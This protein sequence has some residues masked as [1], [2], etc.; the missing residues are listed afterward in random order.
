MLDRFKEGPLVHLP[1]EA[2]I[3]PALIEKLKLVKAKGV[4]FQLPA[5]KTYLVDTPEVQNYVKN[6]VNNFRN[7]TINVVFDLTPNFVTT[8]DELYRSALNETKYRGAFVWVEGAAEPTKWRSLDG[9]NA[10]KEVKAQNWVLSQFGVNN[11]DLQ[12]NNPIAKDKFKNVLQTL[13]SLGVKGFRLANAKH[14]IIDSKDLKDE[15][16][17]DTIG[18]VHD[19][20]NFWNHQQTTFQPGLGQ[21]LEEFANTVRNYTNNEGFLA[22]SN[23]VERPEEF[24][25]DD[26]HFGFDLPIHTNLPHTLT[27]SGPGV[28]KQLYT[29]LSLAVNNLGV[30][31]WGQWVYNGTVDKLSTGLSEY[32][33]FLFL[34]PGVPVGTVEHFVGNNG[35]D[36]QNLHLLEDIRSGASYQHGTF[37][38]Y[39]D[40]NET[41]VAY[42]RFVNSINL[43]L[44]HQSYLSLLT[45]LTNLIENRIITLTTTKY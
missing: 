42:T 32:N 20:Y 40:A 25:N 43:K 45:P 27:T 33:I 38:V 39:L 7:T 14:Y 29:Q 24:K 5:D 44:I 11:I 23:D 22:V 10:W 9:G 36:L 41:V 21:L 18:A 30:R 3:E 4:I 28:A 2:T 13:I 31:T 8:E 26:G 1:S 17:S 16:R 34:L 37:D 15:T 6:L 35:T 19:D 12:L